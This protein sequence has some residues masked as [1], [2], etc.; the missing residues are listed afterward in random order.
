M[1]SIM[2]KAETI[3]SWIQSSKTDEHLDACRDMIYVLAERF[4]DHHNMPEIKEMLLQMISR[5]REELE[6]A[7]PLK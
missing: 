3:R 6:L 4:A 7:N 5:K 2:T 1:E